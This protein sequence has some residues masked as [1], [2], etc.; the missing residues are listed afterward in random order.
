MNDAQKLKDCIAEYH[1]SN[2]KLDDKLTKIAD[3]NRRNRRAAEAESN[4]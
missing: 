2:K 4:R 1:K 3:D